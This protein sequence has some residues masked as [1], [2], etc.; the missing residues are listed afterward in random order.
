MRNIHDAS[1]FAKIENSEEVLKWELAL[2]VGGLEAQPRPVDLSLRDNE[3]PIMVYIFH[4]RHS[5]HGETLLGIIMH[6]SRGSLTRDSTLR[7]FLMTEFNAEGPAALRNI[8]RQ[9]QLTLMSQLKGGKT[10]GSKKMGTFPVDGARPS[11]AKAVDLPQA[12]PAKLS[13]GG[14]KSV[15]TK[16]SQAG[17]TY[18]TKTSA[19]P[20][21]TRSS[22]KA[23]TEGQD[24]RTRVS[25]DEGAPK[26]QNLSPVSIKTKAKKHGPPPKMPKMRAGDTG[27]E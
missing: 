8:Q 6:G 1:G 12:H 10:S 24:R 16:P 22:P 13:T 3:P 27:S 5:L 20:P 17:N 9:R 4:P 21:L 19:S 26:W 11:S 14:K 7:S 23:E 2:F 15:A 18:V 25:M